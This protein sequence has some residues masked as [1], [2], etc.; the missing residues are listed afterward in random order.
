MSSESNKETKKT[1]E[2]RERNSNIELLRIICAV[3]VI[4]F[5]TVA[6]Y[7]IVNAANTAPTAATCIILRFFSVFSIVAVNIF[8]LISGYFMINDDRRKIGKAITLFAVCIAYKALPYL[9]VVAYQGIFLGQSTFSISELLYNLFPRSYFV[10]LYCAL[11]ILSPYINR[12]LRSLTKKGH[13]RLIIISLCLFSVWST[14]INIYMKA[15]GNTDLIEIS[16]VGYSGTDYGFTLIVF[17]MM[18]IIGAYIGRFGLNIGGLSDRV[19]KYIFLGAY[20]IISCVTSGLCLALPSIA[21][22]SSILG[23][24]SIFVVFAAVALFAA[25]L[26]MKPR[27]VAPINFLAKST[28][29]VYLLHAFVLERIVVRTAEKLFGV[30]SLFNGSP[31]IALVAFLAIV[32][33]AYIFSAALDT[34]ARFIFSPVTKR[35]KKTRLYNADIT[36]VKENNGEGE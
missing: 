10:Y 1:T 19:Q 2:K 33:L 11:Y 14:G 9:V 16:F 36:A 12:A 13:L 20:V 7:G 35:W 30:E 6:G 28:F 8:I 27:H 3:M 22:T 17:V 26:K 23:Y 31:A 5:H 24:D 18:Y 32:L 29:G 34:V 21:Q 25:F 4:V 15:S